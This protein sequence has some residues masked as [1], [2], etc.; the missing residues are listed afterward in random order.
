[1]KTQILRPSAFLLLILHKRA[2]QARGVADIDPWLV[3]ILCYNGAGP[4]YYS[5][6][7]G[8]RQDRGICPDADVIPYFCFF[9]EVPVA[10][11]GTA[12]V[13]QIVDEHRPM[14]N[15]AVVSNHHQLTDEGVRLNPTSL[16]N[17]H[18]F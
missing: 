6:A 13:E 18:S 3:D 8:N 15:E 14:R 17:P 7:N 10:A 11:R 1:M 2:Q 16:S 9:P 4:D 5:I 12:G